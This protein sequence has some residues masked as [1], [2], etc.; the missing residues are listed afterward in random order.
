MK[1]TGTSNGQWTGLSE[2]DFDKEMEDL[3]QRII[4]PKSKKAVD[5]L[6][7]AT[8]EEINNAYKPDDHP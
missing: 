6:F 2:E 1:T 7:Q 5:R 4:S 8:D 3:Y